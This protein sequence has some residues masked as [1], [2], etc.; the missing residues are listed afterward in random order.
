MV[1]ITLLIVFSVLPAHNVAQFFQVGW[2][3]IPVVPVTALDVL[4]DAVQI[5]CIQVQKFLLKQTKLQ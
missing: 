3:E 5:Q 2:C 1:F 4:F